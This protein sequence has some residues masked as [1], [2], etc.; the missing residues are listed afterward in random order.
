[1]TESSSSFPVTLALSAHWH[2]YPERFQWIATQDFALEY[3]PNPH[4]FQDLPKH[5]DPI[6]K[7]GILVRHHGFFPGHEIAHSDGAQAEDAVRLHLAALDAMQGRGEQIITLHIGLKPDLPLDHGRAIENLAR[8]ADY[9]RQRGITIALENLRRGP[10]SHPDALIDWASQAETM[11]TLDVGHATSNQHVVNGEL[12]AQDFVDAVADRLVE[13][14]MYERETDRH[15]APKD[16]RV[17]GPIVD[18]LLHT[19]CRWWTIELNE[20]EDALT[21]RT[22]LHDYVDGMHGGEEVEHCGT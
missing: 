7:A 3:S 14:H 13:V 12:T 21:T 18:R 11:I 10:T 2:T 9:A 15:H 16:M 6:L 5:L 1:M 19:D 22:L 17:L 8:I 20:Y 4:A